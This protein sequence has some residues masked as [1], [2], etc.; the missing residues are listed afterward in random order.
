MSIGWKKYTGTS[1]PAVMG[2]TIVETPGGLA[3][4]PACKLVQMGGNTGDPIESGADSPALNYNFWWWDGEDWHDSGITFPTT[5]A[6]TAGGVLG[7]GFFDV[8]RKLIVWFPGLTGHPF[9]I[10]SPGDN[11]IWSAV[12]FDGLNT[13][14]Y[15]DALPE[16]TTGGSAFGSSSNAA[17]W[18][19]TRGV[20]VLSPGAGAGGLYASPNPSH[21]DYSASTHKLTPVVDSSNSIPQGASAC[22][23][24]PL[25]QVD[26]FGDAGGGT[27]ALG[28]GSDDVV[29]VNT[30]GVD[31]SDTA[32]F[33]ASQY[34]AMAFVPP[35]SAPIMKG[36]QY[37]WL[38]THSA[39]GM[40][41]VHHHATWSRV[42]LTSEGP[43]VVDR[44]GWA[45]GCDGSQLVLTGGRDRTAGALLT[46]TWILTF[47]IPIAAVAGY[48]TS[49][50]TVRVILSVEPQHEDSFIPGD[51]LNPTTWS[52]V[53]ARGNVYTPLAV[54]EVSPETYDVMLLS[55]LADQFTTHT[56]SSSTL[57]GSNGLAIPDPLSAD[58]LG[59]VA[60]NDALR[61]SP[62]NAYRD[63]DIRN[64]PFNAGG[65][66]GTP[67]IGSDNDYENED[68]VDLARKCI[69]RRLGTTIDSFKHLKGYGLGAKEKELIPGGGLIKYKAE[70]NGQ[71]AQE[72]DM[73]TV[74]TT[75]MLDRD[76]VLTISIAA[77][78]RST[79]AS[80]NVSVVVRD[81]N[82]VEI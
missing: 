35:I 1:P 33:R 53:D 71:I 55:G 81:G 31:P 2:H 59:C 66:S 65:L 44:P 18:D 48:A 58:F 15:A 29:A 36:P 72:P 20:G 27:L 45:M 49:T 38:L 61:A 23:I 54:T 10:F 73:K 37:T 62:I 42:S 5:K 6:G 60:E 63:R 41:D 46:G 39:S 11:Q 40:L 70:I 74:D 68:G 30:G 50:N 7:A 43:Q 12:E 19:V 24:S 9:N 67:I 57:L 82:L 14:V 3:N 8:T 13:D 79:G 76:G 52:I 22:W 64:P 34:L 80:V 51:A 47:P 75:L 69:I 4:L 26:L 77:T 25:A 32:A 28:V 56:I 21:W 17:W 16:L 78:L